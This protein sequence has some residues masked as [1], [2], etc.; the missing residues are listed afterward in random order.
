[1]LKKR[2]LLVASDAQALADF[3][4]DLGEAWEVVV[5]ADGA[6]ALAEL[7]QRPGHVV[8]V[9]L[10]Q[11]EEAGLELLNRIQLAHPKIIRFILAL[12][13][14]RERVMKKSLGVNQFLGKPLEAGSVQRAFERALALEAWIPRNS[15][16]EL[17]ARVRTL[18][19][20][21]S[22]YLEVQA[23]LKSPDASTEEIGAIIAKDMAMMTKLLQVLNSAAYGLQRKITNPAEAV[24]LL[25]FE[26]V[27]SMVM[28]IKVLG[29]CDKVKPVYFSIDRLWKHSTE[30]ARNAKELA[31]M[32]TSDRALAEL[33]FTGGLMHDLG[34][35]VLAANFDEQYSGAQSLARKQKLP[36][37]EV[38]KEIFGAT[39]GEVGAY[40]LGLWGMPLEILEVAALHHQP[41]TGA[42]SGFTALTAVHFANAIE[43][44]NHPEKDGTVASKLDE[45][46]LAKVGVLE[47]ADAWRT[48]IAT[49]HF[50]KIEIQ[51]KAP[52]VP[53]LQKAPPEKEKPAIVLKAASPAPARIPWLYAGIA[54]AAVIV[55]LLCMG[56]E[57]VLPNRADAPNGKPSST[58]KVIAALAPVQEVRART[59]AAPASPAPPQPEPVVVKPASPE[60]AP[61]IQTKSNFS[62]F[63][64]QG[65][66]FSA[67]HPQAI[68]NGK[69]VQPGDRVGEAVVLSV[70]ESS[71]TLEYQKQTR[72]LTLK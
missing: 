33:A 47:Y 3:Q 45:E 44:E 69:T 37:W 55:I 38:E 58:A 41:V 12:E 65:I 21:P 35:V 68:I 25:G 51:P 71:V 27:S 39:H 57:F 62:D 6:A 50:K 56:F 34:K 11:A 61:T 72:V 19:T 43:H 8:V 29:D 64:L 1:M 31:L 2:I 22:L 49:R 10:T 67:S 59:E 13:V 17:V 16:R 18:P 15:V 36:L 63:K 48:A 60:V 24:G 53:K 9:D 42:T 26:T 46:Y 32:H 7:E 66:F 4:R 28:A 20:I 23:L 5:A 52:A 70:K 14:E 54:T 40:L 30:V